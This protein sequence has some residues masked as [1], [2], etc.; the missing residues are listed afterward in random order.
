MRASMAYLAGAG[1]IVV[2]IAIGLGGGLIAGNIMNPQLPKQATATS[3]LERRPS[4]EAV[5]VSAAAAPASSG[6]QDAMAASDPVPYLAETRRAGFG[7]VLASNGAQ[8]NSAQGRASATDDHNAADASSGQ[9]ARGDQQGTAEKA[10]SP[11][12]AYA[13]ARDSDARRE[14]AERR[15]AERRQ[16][17]AERHRRDRQQPTDWSDVDRRVRED[18]DSRDYGR[19]GYGL[20]Q[21]RLFGND[22]D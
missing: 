8:G 3:K 12:D 6:G 22:D 10:T 14:A 1:T 17:W 13:K 19:S 20:P 21:V 18:A 16:R 5:G 11:E 2:A 9:A 4:T 15:R 7:A